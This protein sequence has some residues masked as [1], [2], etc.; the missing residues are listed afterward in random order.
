MMRYTKVLGLALLFGIG[1]VGRG[2][3]LISVSYSLG[4]GS[5]GVCVVARELVQVRSPVV[6]TL[7]L[8]TLL[9]LY[10]IA[11]TDRPAHPANVQSQRVADNRVI[12]VDRIFIF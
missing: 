9:M 7:S 3:V 2:A 11:H 12:D 10:C 4:N 5:C 6:Q 1:C 8:K